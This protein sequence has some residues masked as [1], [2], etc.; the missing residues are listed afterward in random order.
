VETAGVMSGD[1]AVRRL[2][3]HALLDPATSHVV[4]LPKWCIPLY[5]FLYTYQYITES[6]QSFL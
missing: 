2:M 4:L 5:S 6:Q 3:V 1:I